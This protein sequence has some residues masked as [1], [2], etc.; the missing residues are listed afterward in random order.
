MKHRLFSIVTIL[1]VMSSL[2]IMGGGAV[3]AQQ[4]VTTAGAL[5]IAK[6]EETD[7][8]A[9]VEQ[10]AYAEAYANV[11]G[12][13]EDCIR[14]TQSQADI[15]AR[16]YAEADADGWA[17][18]FIGG[19]EFDYDYGDNGIGPNGVSG[20]YF[21]GGPYID[22]SSSGKT[23]I[24]ASAAAFGNDAYA[25]VEIED[26]DIYDGSSGSITINA[27]STA[28]GDHA[29]A[30]IE[31][32]DADI[33]AHSSGSI[34]IQAT[35]TATGNNSIANI[36]EVELDIDNGASGS[37]YA[38]ISVTA[39]NGGRAYNDIDAGIS[40]TNGNY[41]IYSIANSTG[42][43]SHYS[44]ADNDI[45]LYSDPVPAGVWVDVDAD[46]NAIAIALLISD[47]TNV[48]A[49]AY[50]DAW[51]GGTAAATINGAG[52]QGGLGV[53]AEVGFLLEG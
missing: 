2:L 10:S 9:A 50:T 40:G 25:N 51:G 3:F 44:Y 28:T 32:E 49:I 6:G 26:A 17:E 46:S 8:K 11:P 39:T 7:A 45:N 4:S 41:T 36:T 33:G 24:T 22:N 43:G 30:Y 35:A 34:E 47:G 23:D 15:T 31:I 14:G 16:A 5:A 29:K 19:W 12:I 37:I 21:Y 53:D 42:T 48:W 18:V 1:A 38:E 20:Y 13:L 27:T 52:M